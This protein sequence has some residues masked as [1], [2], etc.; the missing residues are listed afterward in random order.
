MDNV[1]FIENVK[2]LC[3]SKNV[4]VKQCLEDCHINRNFMYD[5]KNGKKP[6]IEVIETLSDYFNVSADYL[7]GRT[8]NI[9]SYSNNNFS[10]STNI[11]FGKQS[12]VNGATEHDE[13]ETELL[14][15]FRKI[16]FPDKLRF[17]SD[18]MKKA[19]DKE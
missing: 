12:V 15:N 10:N 17:V 7:L 3:Q 18:V 2:N 8:E 13:I 19:E 9:Q 11:A 6:S 4:T 1:Q 5:T 16:S 14:K